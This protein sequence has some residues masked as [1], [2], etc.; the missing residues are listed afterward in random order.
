MLA[1]VVDET[2]IHRR[3]NL[4][5]QVILRHQFFQQDYLVFVLPTSASLSQHF[6]HLVSL[7]FTIRL[8]LPFFQYGKTSNLH[9]WRFVD[10]LKAPQLRGLP[11]YSKMIC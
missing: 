7:R 9:G 10:G 2:E 3:V 8:H 5:Q 4:P 6:P 1:Q 11:C